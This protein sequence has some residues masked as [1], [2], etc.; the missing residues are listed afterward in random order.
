MSLAPLAAT[1]VKTDD[2]ELA[3]PSGDRA[4]GEICS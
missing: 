1:N 3:E 2:L 4:A